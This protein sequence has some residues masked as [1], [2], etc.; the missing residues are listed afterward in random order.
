[1]ANIKAV[2]GGIY[3]LP[4]F[5]DAEW[6]AL[7][8]RNNEKGVLI[9]YFYPNL[10]SISISVPSLVRQV[11]DTGIRNGEWKLV[12]KLPSWKRDDWPLPKFRRMAPGASPSSETRVVSYDDNMAGI[13]Q[14]QVVSDSCLQLPLDG[15]SGH[16]AIE[17]HL[18]RLE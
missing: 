10:Q 6:H 17:V 7:I 2:E 15:L 14:V 8:T 1:M 18:K 13:G 11:T 12:A 5:S 3:S 9:G 4:R 16:K